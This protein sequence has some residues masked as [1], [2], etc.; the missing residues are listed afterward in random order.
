MENRDRALVTLKAVTLRLGDRW[1]LPGT[2][3]EI[4]TGQ[5]WAVV[6]ANGAGKTSLVRAL[7]GEIPVVRGTIER[8][9]P[10]TDR[11]AVG[12]VSFERHREFIGREDRRDDARFFGGTPDARTTVEQLVRGS[13]GAENHRTGDVGR[14][15]GMLGI[16]HLLDRG[17]RFLST[18][19]M[20][21]ALIAGALLKSPRLLVL[22]E[23]FDGLDPA[24]R[25]QLHRIIGKVTADGTQLIL[26]THREEEIPPAVSHIIRLGPDGVSV[27]TRANGGAAA[28]PVRRDEG[29]VPVFARPRPPRSPEPG[30]AGEDGPRT[31][32]VEMRDVTVRYGGVHALRRLNWTM[33]RGQNWAVVGPNGSGKTTLLR[34]IY[35]DIPQA[36]ANEI[37]LFGKRRGTGE[38]IWEIR[39]RIGMVGS[40]LQIHYRRPLCALDVVCSGFHD[41]VGLFRRVDARQED[42]GR[43]WMSTLGIAELASRPFDRLSC[44]EQRMVLIARAVVKSPELLLLDEPCQGLDRR[45]RRQVLDLIAAIGARTATQMV[46]V[47]H[48][49]TD[50][51]PCFTRKLR[52]P[53][54]REAR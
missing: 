25:R 36:Y 49:E 21:K 53:Q 38:S 46:Y 22:D 15:A 23:P 27:S 44:G 31:N 32:L 20:R 4:K 42:A 51:D 10:E 3:W 43:R 11:E 7:A 17:I 12:F 39:R 29:P 40:E 30:T 14:V 34:L 37:Y 35:A 52:M 33:K 19:E 26:V 54:G 41:S 50:I 1:L 18:G 16:A 48:H 13:S 6:G 5:H 47:T 9:Y 8:H 2:S 24:S 28:I 45:H